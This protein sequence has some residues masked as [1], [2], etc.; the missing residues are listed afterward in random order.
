MARGGESMGAAG[1]SGPPRRRRR[2]CPGAVLVPG[3]V[4]CGG[5]P[6]WRWVANRGGAGWRLPDCE[7]LAAVRWPFSHH[8]TAE[9]GS[10]SGNRHL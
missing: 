2:P 4:I 9:I 6:G 7:E 5:D 1:S 8:L 10:E 3:A